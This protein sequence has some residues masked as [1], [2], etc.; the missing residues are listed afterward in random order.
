MK[1]AYDL[2]KVL[3]PKYQKILSFD[4]QEVDNPD[5]YSNARLNYYDRLNVIIQ[6]VSSRLKNSQ[7]VKI[8]DFAAAQGNAGLLLSELGY[9]V[10]LIDINEMF[11]SYSKEKYEK[12]KVSW[13]V[14]N[15]EDLDIAKESLDVAIAGELIEHCA[16]P[17]DILQQILTFVRPGGLLL[18]T[19]PNGASLRSNLPSFSELSEKE[20][21][22]KFEETQF[23]PDGED[24]LFLFKIEEI[25]MITP[26][27][28]SIIES[29]YLGG[30]FLLNR[31]PKVL[32][33]LFPSEL[34]EHAIRFLSKFPVINRYISNNIYTVFSKN[35]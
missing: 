35:S 8:G 14:S 19:T 9:E 10:L 15:I 20:L 5:R 33:E 30:T 1:N 21:R 24:H 34:I 17:E 29:G 27:N 13:I 3:D 31:F 7:N 6:I 16:Y 23:G 28:C 22:K 25:D 26:K 18:I 2:E 4:K 32:L 12:G 11:I